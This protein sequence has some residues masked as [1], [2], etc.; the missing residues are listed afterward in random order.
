MSAAEMP[1][2][3]FYLVRPTPAV[4]ARSHHLHALRQAIQ[5]QMAAAAQEAQ[6]S[7]SADLEAIHASIGADL[8]ALKGE[9]H[10]GTTPR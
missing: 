5:A 3:E 1:S 6:L 10:R 8:H 7:L 9:W 4:V 2:V